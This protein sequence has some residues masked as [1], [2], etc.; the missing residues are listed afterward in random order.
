LYSVK[1]L[2]YKN[3]MYFMKRH[4]P[5]HVFEAK[6]KMWLKTLFPIVYDKFKK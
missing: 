3:H 5:K 6:A 4:F 1:G 2:S